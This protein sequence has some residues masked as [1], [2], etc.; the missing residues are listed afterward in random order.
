MD[1]QSLLVKHNVDIKEEDYSEIIRDDYEEF[2]KH[3]TRVLEAE[4]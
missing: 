2:L 1:L 3:Q 4:F